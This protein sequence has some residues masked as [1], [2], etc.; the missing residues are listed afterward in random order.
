[1]LPIVDQSSFSCPE[2]AP[3]TSVQEGN[4]A[5]ASSRQTAFGERCYTLPAIFVA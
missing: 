5:M 2:Q 1:M 3:W 4:V